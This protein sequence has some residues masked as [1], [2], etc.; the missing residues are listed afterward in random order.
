MFADQSFTAPAHSM[1]HD[2]TPGW[3]LYVEKTLRV[4]RFRFF[5]RTKKV[6]VGP[7]QMPFPVEAGDRLIAKFNP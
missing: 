6:I 5:T 4:K 3:D 2:I 7:V 1:I